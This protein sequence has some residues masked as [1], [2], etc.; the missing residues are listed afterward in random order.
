MRYAPV[1]DQN[2]PLDETETMRYKRKSRVLWG[3]ELVI[4]ML[5]YFVQRRYGLVLAVSHL[6]LSFMLMV[7]KLRFKL[8]KN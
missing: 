2:K 1:P 8:Y 7:G 4:G 5:L 3:L 6:F